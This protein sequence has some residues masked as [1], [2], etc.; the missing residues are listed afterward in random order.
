MVQISTVFGGDPVYWTLALLG[1]DQHA[2]LDDFELIEQVHGLH[3]SRMWVAA[4]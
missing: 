4:E 2:M 3:L 1:T